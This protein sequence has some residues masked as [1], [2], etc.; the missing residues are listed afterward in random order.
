MNKSSQATETVE[1]TASEEVLV[2]VLAAK[3][4]SV[5]VL[6]LNSEKTLNA[7]SLQMVR[8]LTQS[9]KDWAS[10]DDIQAVILK[11][12]GSKAF[13]A[14]GDVQALYRS[15]IAQQD[16]AC[17][18]AEQFFFEE[19]QLNYLIHTYYKPIICIGHGF[20]M[21]GGLGL[22]AG[23]SH[24]VITD[25][26]KLAMPEITIGLFPDV[27]GT[28]FLNQVPY[29]LGYFL[30]LT[31]VAINAA[32]TLFC[33]LAD[34]A[35][36]LN[37]VEKLIHAIS[38]L[39]FSEENDNN[40]LLVTEA[41]KA[42]E[43]TSKQLQSSQIKLNLQVLEQACQHNSL[44]SITDAIVAFDESNTFLNKS[45]QTLLAG[46]PLSL[47]AIYEQLKRHRYTDLQN[48]FTSELV[49]AT[50]MIRHPDFAEGV[51]ALL[52][53]KDKTPKWEYAH[54]T[55]IPSSVIESLF[56]R[57]WDKNPLDGLLA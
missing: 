16:G 8:L 25:T 39:E 20:V 19:Y 12:Q 55:H 21:G 29:N 43:L 4:G 41:I 15:A 17:I 32:D 7:L 37:D 26:T 56:S 49:L 5:G 52:I 38:K 45:K 13:C 14:G 23:A 27:G 34:F 3:N 36:E 31:G 11:G 50:N 22:L 33:R 18:D 57:P 54:Y 53:D 9:L 2:E 51:R 48:A 1:T 28:Q 42:L 46:S 40:H 47:V 10:N 24:R 44:C 6:T 30:A 35:I